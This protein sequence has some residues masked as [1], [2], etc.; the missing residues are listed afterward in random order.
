MLKDKA[1]Q[2][3]ERFRND[4]PPDIVRVV[5]IH[6][7]AG[8]TDSKWSVFIGKTMARANNYKRAGHEVLV[9]YSQRNVTLII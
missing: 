6:K 1:I 4:Y 8:Q 7:P 5:G 9:L 2:I 3:A